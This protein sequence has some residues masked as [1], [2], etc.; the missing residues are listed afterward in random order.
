LAGPGVTDT[1]L[2]VPAAGCG[3]E[4]KGVDEGVDF[5][6]T[7]RGVRAWTARSEGVDLAL[8][9]ERRRGL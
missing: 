1:S 2:P 4:D 9:S 6:G 8:D 7:Q 5:R 3:G